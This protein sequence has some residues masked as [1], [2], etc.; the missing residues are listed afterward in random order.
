MDTPVVGLRA[1]LDGSRQ[2]VTTVPGDEPPTTSTWQIA[3]ARLTSIAAPVADVDRLPE[4]ES[5]I[6]TIGPEQMALGPPR[7]GGFL[8]VAEAESGVPA[9]APPLTGTVST[10]PPPADDTTD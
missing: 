10:L 2:P 3:G 1:L 8:T 7:G 6:Q 4:I 9:T 5:L